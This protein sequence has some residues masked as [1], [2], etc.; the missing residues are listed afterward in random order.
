M[1]CGFC[2]DRLWYDREVVCPSIRWKRVCLICTQLTAIFLS[3]SQCAVLLIV[4]IFPMLISR[5]LT[6]VAR[7]SRNSIIM[8]LFL[9]ATMV[10]VACTALAKGKAAKVHILPTPLDP[11]CA[12]ECGTLTRMAVAI[13]SVLS[14]SCLAFTCQV[15]YE[16]FLHHFSTTRPNELTHYEYYPRSST[17]CRSTN[18]CATVAVATC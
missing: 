10:A 8:M 3:L 1:A 15:T 16:R 18:H 13:L 7:Y 14:V 2:R 12:S 9:S 5:D 6:V 17:C 11:A 4:A